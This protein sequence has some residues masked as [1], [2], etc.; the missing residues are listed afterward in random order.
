MNKQTAGGNGRAAV[1]YTLL[2][3]VTVSI[4]AVTFASIAP[5]IERPWHRIANAL[6]QPEAAASESYNLGMPGP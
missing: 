3:F 5:V 1:E 4:I 6:R 2:A